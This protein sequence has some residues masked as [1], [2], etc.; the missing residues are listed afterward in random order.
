MT[1]QGWND[2]TFKFDT[3]YEFMIVF[4]RYDSIDDDDSEAISPYYRTTVNPA[5]TT[6]PL[7][8]DVG[9][10]TWLRFEYA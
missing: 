8:G 5:N 9:V 3:D 6:D 7:Y 10:H 4:G 2:L 1:G